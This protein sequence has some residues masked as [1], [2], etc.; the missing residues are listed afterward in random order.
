MYLSDMIRQ[1][2]VDDL[3]SIARVHTV[4]FPKS[5]ST[6]LGK[7]S[8]D[9]IDNLLCK[10][11]LEY[12]HDA[13]ELFKVA[14][15][16][17]NNIVGFCMGYFMDKDDQMQNFIRHNRF[18]VLLHTVFLLIRGNKP[19]WKKFI[20]RFSHGDN[21]VQKVVNFSNEDINNDKRGD[22]LSVCV[23]PEYRGKKYAQ[24]L[25]EAFLQS[26]KDSG[27]VLCLLSVKTD[28]ERAIHYYEKNGFIL[29][30]TRGSVG[31]TYMKLL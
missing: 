26:M 18:R 2:Q 25:M 28:N 14:V 7:S 8:R 24:Q 4:C 23:L 17:Q 30:R 5:Y 19:T 10:F 27:R 16:E 20:S 21:T 3:P 29:Y 31:R 6:Q 12:L 22:L 15:N 9:G 1:A 13:P 11:Y